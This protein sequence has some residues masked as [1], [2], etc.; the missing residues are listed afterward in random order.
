MAGPRHTDYAAARRIAK[1]LRNRI[2]S[3]RRPR[4]HRL[5]MLAQSSS[6]DWIYSSITRTVLSRSTCTH[7][8]TNGL[9]YPKS[10]ARYS[11][12]SASYAV[13]LTC[14]S[15]R[16]LIKHR[17]FHLRPQTQHLG[18][19]PRPA[20]AP[21]LVDH[22]VNLQIPRRVFRLARAIL[23]QRTLHTFRSGPH[24]LNHLPHTPL[25]TPAAATRP[26]RQ[27]AAASPRT[28]DASC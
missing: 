10:I 9:E 27:S 6:R 3:A 7:R 20:A 14:T 13:G 24:R 28:A 8:H 12:S 11:G 21:H 22:I 19:K 25:E 16:E 2:H 1:G 18:L 23:P 15:G 26:P 5:A 4:N 17:P